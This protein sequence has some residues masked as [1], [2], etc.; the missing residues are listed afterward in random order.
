[1]RLVPGA[2]LIAKSQTKLPNSW[3]D[4]PELTV[5]LGTVPGLK[6]DVTDMTVQAGSQVKLIFSNN[7]DMPHN[8]LLVQPNA[9]SRVGEMSLK[10]GVKGMA[11]D[12]VPNTPLVLSHTKLVQPGSSQTIYFQAPEEPGVYE[13]VCTYPGHYMTMRGV[14]RVRARESR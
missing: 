13:Y 1:P 12:Y 6:Y 10:L 7:D 14:L 11:M 2:E 9:A 5:R 8:F 3:E 4:G